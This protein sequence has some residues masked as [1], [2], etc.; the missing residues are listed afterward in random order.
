MS[1]LYPWSLTQLRTPHTSSVPYPTIDPF[2]GKYWVA[3]DL[4]KAFRDVV[5]HRWVAWKTAGFVL[6]EMAVEILS[7]WPINDEM[8]AQDE[9]RSADD[10]EYLEEQLP[11]LWEIVK[12]EPFTELERDS[13]LSS[14]QNL[15]EPEIG[16]EIHAMQSAFLAAMVILSTPGPSIEHPYSDLGAG[17]WRL[18]IAV[19]DTWGSEAAYEMY[20]VWWNRTFSRLAFVQEEEP[21]Y[22]EEE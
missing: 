2:A 17:L 16:T 18:F 13:L 15:F 6:Y 21:E 3:R 9:F 20:R 5:G 19:D 4:V 10:I 14:L 22:D 7:A 11:Y 12:G 1:Q 8:G